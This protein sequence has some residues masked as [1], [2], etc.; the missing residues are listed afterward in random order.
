MNP[1]ILS[2]MLT[3]ALLLS[4]FAGCGSAD[5]LS[6]SGETSSG[7]R[8]QSFMQTTDD[9]KTSENEAEPDYPWFTFPEETNKLTVY[10]NG[11]D[12][13]SVLDPAIRI[14]KE[15]YP[16][17]FLVDYVRVYKLAE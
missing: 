12:L 2:L 15:Q 6:T 11:D 4:A 16:D 1:R 13:K 17:E 3:L 9:E 7:K 10:S 5:T 8:E 14:F